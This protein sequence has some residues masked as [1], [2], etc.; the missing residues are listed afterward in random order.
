MQTILR[1]KFPDTLL[2]PALLESAAALWLEWHLQALTGRLLARQSY[3]RVEAQLWGVP[4]PDIEAC[5]ARIARRAAQE[6]PDSSVA[7]SDPETVSV[8]S[9]WR[10][11]SQPAALARTAGL[12]GEEFEGMRLTLRLTAGEWRGM[13]DGL[14]LT[15][16]T[17]VLW[18]E[19]RGGAPRLRGTW[20]A[21]LT[22]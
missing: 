14:P 16:G 22:G 3:H 7:L 8:T 4:R 5:R 19:L 9:P 11:I 2:E 13:P 15:E 17:L 6:L 10:E 18:T 1:S 21:D 20:P 12:F